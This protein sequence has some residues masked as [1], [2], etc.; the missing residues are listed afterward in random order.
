M[1]NIDLE[2]KLNNL[3]NTVLENSIYENEFKQLLKQL[4]V[5][6]KQLIKTVIN[7]T[8]SGEKF[9]NSKYADILMRLTLH[10]HNLVEDSYHIEKGK[11]VL[12]YVLKNNPRTLVDIGYGIPSEYV[13][14]R[15][16]NNKQITLVDQD[17]SAEIVSRA[18]FDIRKLN[19]KYVKYQNH[20]MNSNEYI[21][22]YDTY[23]MLDSI[24]H[25]FE[26]T[27]YLNQLIEKSPKKSNFIFSIP[28]MK[29]YN[30]DDSKVNHFHYAEW[31]TVNDAKNWLENTNLQI[32]DS[33]LL[34]PNPNIDFFAYKKNSSK[35][36][37]KCF[38]V[39][40]KKNEYNS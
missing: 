13:F 17:K 27:K 33:K 2:S 9:E 6:K 36:T 24:E 29:N 18:I 19:Q 14:N 21:G 26:P 35:P 40:C 25:S 15:L 30:E 22:D 10:L 38:M 28:I 39:N 8:T 5:S 34:V 11:T 4:K 20:N 16:K 23:I 32:T 7:Y 1:K 31:L 12:A 37:Y 3:A